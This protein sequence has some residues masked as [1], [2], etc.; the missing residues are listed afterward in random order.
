MKGS[1]VDEEK[2]KFLTVC[3]SHGDP[4][5]LDDSDVSGNALW[6][7]NDVS[8]HRID[9]HDVV[10]L[11]YK[12]SRPTC[13][14]W[15]DSRV[16]YRQNFHRDYDYNIAINLSQH[17]W[18]KNNQR[19]RI[20]LMEF[21]YAVRVATPV[22]DEGVGVFV[23]KPLEVRALR[24]TPDSFEQAVAIAAWC[25]GVGSANRTTGPQQWRIT[26]AGE[27]C[28]WGEWIVRHDSEFDGDHFSRF[29]VLAPDA[30]E[31]LYTAKI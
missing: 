31:G 8:M 14:R 23:T 22:D 3:L 20:R 4:Q 17:F 30:F 2:I 1:G 19:N 24:W 5:L 28:S 10:V 21:L 25:G 27:E 9:G 16:G 7:G 29:E 18:T 12:N 11:E 6:T 26:V 15:F 13:V